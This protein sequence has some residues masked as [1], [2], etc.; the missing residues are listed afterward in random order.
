MLKSH[1]L[2]DTEVKRVTPK[3][4]CFLDGE[5]RTKLCAE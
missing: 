1:K 3:I 5:F 4:V 2:F